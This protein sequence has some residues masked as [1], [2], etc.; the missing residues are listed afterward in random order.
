MFFVFIHLFVLFFLY[1]LECRLFMKF[2][3]IEIQQVL[4]E[5]LQLCVTSFFLQY[6]GYFWSLIFV[7]FVLRYLQEEN[8]NM[9]KGIM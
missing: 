3:K 9:L 6:N 8:L 5:L 1:S 4:C 2:S 7:T